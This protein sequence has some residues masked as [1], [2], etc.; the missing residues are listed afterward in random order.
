MTVEDV[1]SERISA[2]AAPYNI[3]E[4]ADTIQRLRPDWKA[5]KFDSNDD[6]DLSIIEEKGRAEE[7][8]AKVGKQGGF[9]GLEDMIKANIEGR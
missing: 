5:P 3:K 6:K 8:L 9:T 4:L 2:Y 1:Q 7:L